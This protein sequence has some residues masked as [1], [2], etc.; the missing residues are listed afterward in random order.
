MTVQEFSKNYLS[1]LMKLLFFGEV[2]KTL[3]ILAAIL[4]PI[5]LPVASASFE[6]LFSKQF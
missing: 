3:V 5:K 2:F 1:I 4:F 6:L